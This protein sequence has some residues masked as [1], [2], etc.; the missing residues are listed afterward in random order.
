L[1]D[2]VKNRNTN[3]ADKLASNRGEASIKRAL[4]SGKIGPKEKATALAI[5]AHAKAGK[6]PLQ[7][8]SLHQGPNGEVYLKAGHSINAGGSLVGYLQR[9]HYIERKTMI[10]SLMLPRSTVS[11]TASLQPPNC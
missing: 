8:D 5:L 9:R 3:T 7:P 6:P 2:Q 11:P 1:R 4:N 10:P